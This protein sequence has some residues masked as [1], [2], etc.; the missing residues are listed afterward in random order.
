[1]QGISQAARDALVS[2]LRQTTPALE[3]E[4]VCNATEPAV[5]SI[6]S[7]GNLSSTYLPPGDVANGLGESFPY[8]VLDCGCLADGTWFP[9]PESGEAEYERGWWSNTTS[10]ANGNFSSPP[11]IEITYAAAAPWRQANYV[12][13][14]SSRY[15]G[16]IAAFKLW[17]KRSTDTSWQGGM[18]H[19]M[20][21]YELLVSLGAAFNLKALRIE[22][23]KTANPN[24]YARLIEVDA[25]WR[26]DLS[27]MLH[28]ITLRKRREHLISA[29]LPYGN[30]AATEL[31]MD[32]IDEAGLFKDGGAYASYRVPNL[33]LAASI[34]VWTGTSYEVIEQGT[35]YTEPDWSFS[36]GPRV[37]FTARD[38]TRFLQEADCEEHLVQGLPTALVFKHLA[39]RAHICTA[40]MV[41]E[42]FPTVHPYIWIGGGSVYDAMAELAEAEWA[43]IY[44]DELG[45]LHID[46]KNHFSGA[47]PIATI[48]DALLASAVIEES[49]RANYV[50]YK[51]TQ[52]ELS[53]RQEVGRLWEE[54]AAPA[55][56]SKT[57]LGSF[58]KQP[59][60][61]ITSPTLTYEGSHL[62]ITSWW[63]NGA[64]WSVTVNNTG[65]T[66]ETI[67]EISWWGQPLALADP[68]QAVAQDKDLIRRHS[69]RTLEIDPPI[70]S[71]SASDAQS[72]ANDLL[73][74]LK[75]GSHRITLEM[76]SQPHWQLADVVTVNSTRA[77]ISGNYI[78]Q[79]IE[80]DQHKMKL[81]LTK[82]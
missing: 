72:R 17:Y 7:S 66:A 63:S 79:Q 74:R 75:T 82:L 56:Q 67:T 60:P 78:I 71:M 69:K 20:T 19:N 26:A 10:D 48:T 42:D 81:E 51:Y 13:I 54:I 25:I 59:V 21:G 35:F 34:G 36:E 49:L 65:D 8:C 15:Y 9:F 2:P 76:A 32:L 43:D 80:L 64:Q 57:I 37:S 46:N 5:Q 1:M 6:T 28:A 61:V 12:R 11:W 53:P 44:F 39:H 45:I 41:V 73:N 47:T 23:T 30:F 22:I 68:K 38:R 16:R 4:F 52:A 62:E 77:K 29:T 70:I 31:E 50:A 27:T 14:T 55:G 3:A 58:N 33:H 24:D 40:D 18:E